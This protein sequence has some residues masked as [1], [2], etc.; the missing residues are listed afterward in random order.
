MHAVPDPKSMRCVHPRRNIL[1]SATPL[2]GQGA[3]YH[4]PAMTGT[5]APP[6]FFLFFCLFIIACDRLTRSWRCVPSH[7]CSPA[8]FGFSPRL[9]LQPSLL[10]SLSPLPKLPLSLCASPSAVSSICRPTSVKV[11]KTRITSSAKTSRIVKR[12]LPLR[13]SFRTPVQ[14][15][16]C[17][18]RHCAILEEMFAGLGL[19]LAAPAFGIGPVCCL[20][21]VSAGQPG[22]VRA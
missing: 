10:F 13:V 16:F 17:W 1:K 21:Y 7:C 4:L 15:I 2:Q 22:H 9:C 8:P 12:F 3:I 19:V 6:F 14:R 20:L 5:T 11:R 18:L